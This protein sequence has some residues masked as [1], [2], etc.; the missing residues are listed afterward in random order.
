MTLTEM[1][2][3][4]HEQNQ[5]RAMVDHDLL[6]RALEAARQADAETTNLR[7]QV[8]SLRKQMEEALAV[9]A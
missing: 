9:P 6:T 7:C 2:K 8:V 1:L 4:L 3:Q 5:A